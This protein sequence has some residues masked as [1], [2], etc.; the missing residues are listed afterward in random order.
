MPI[1]FSMVI[2][3]LS[4]FLVDLMIGIWPVFKTFAQMDLALAGLIGG[5]CA[6]FGEGMQVVFGILSDR[7]WRKFLI[8]A[9]LF[10]TTASAYFAYTD[11]YVGFF[12]LCLL[13]CI[14]SG[15]FH[16]AAVS[17]VSDLPSQRKGF[18]I[19]LFTS[20]GSFGM[21]VGQ[22]AFTQTHSWFDGH[23]A[24]LALPAI[25]VIIAACLGNLGKQTTTQSV[26]PRHFDLK[27]FKHF[28]RHRPL[29]M[30]Y[31]SQVCNAT[32][33]WG[34]L[35]LLPD[36]LLSR[37]YDSWISFGG[38]H[39]V[40][41]IGSATMMMLAGFL[42]DSYSHRSVILVS[43]FCGMIFFYSLI[44]IPALNTIALLV[45]LFGLGAAIGAV[46][47]VSTSLGTLLAPN[48]KGLVSAFLMGLVWCVSEGIGQIGG[49]F[50]ATCFTDDGPAKA[51][52]IMGNLFLI[53][54]ATAYQLPKA[55]DESVAFESV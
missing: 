5:G 48:H 18:L 3:W 52:A 19:G 14:G 45:L 55:V 4:H 20:G 38:G 11:S 33:L 35:F 16:P 25:I 13:T 17:F 22:L 46:N 44:L 15:A 23:T 53:G 12:L 41:I 24:W 51:L 21:A 34:T 54:L 39:L 9:G 36:L 8:L 7:G 43:C 37:G 49:G 10:T 32:M 27:I 50:L 29:R 26:A 31:F 30:L 40:C 42:A 2:I 47:P 6:F 1:L 28:F